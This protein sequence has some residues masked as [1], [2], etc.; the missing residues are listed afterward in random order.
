VLSDQIDT[1]EGHKELS[2]SFQVN[3]NVKYFLIIEQSGDMYAEDLLTQSCTYF[4]LIINLNT[5]DYL[6][7]ELSCEKVDPENKMPRLLDVLPGEITD[8][9][10]DFKIKD[11]YKLEYP[12]DFTLAGEKA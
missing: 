7:K 9:D 10:V 4:N 3:A 6:K 2:F 8:K 11:L 12:K 1:T 5:I